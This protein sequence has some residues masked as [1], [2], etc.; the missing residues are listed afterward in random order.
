MVSNQIKKKVWL[1]LENVCVYTSRGNLFKTMN[2]TIFQLYANT[3][4]FVPALSVHA[5]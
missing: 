3:T 1:L 2:S 4:L 5:S